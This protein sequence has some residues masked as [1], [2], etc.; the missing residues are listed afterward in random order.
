MISLVRLLSEQFVTLKPIE[1]SES[2][3]KSSY[4]S[5]YVKGSTE[6][7]KLIVPVNTEVGELEYGV[8]D[9]T[10]IELIS[11]HIAKVHRG[12]RYATD[13]VNAL[14]HSLKQK[15]IILLAAPSSKK[16]WMKLGFQPMPDAKGYF[17]KTF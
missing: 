6:F 1:P 12:K 7:F 2:D 5:P 11:I 16:F 3:F 10:T 17:T 13:A 4:H 9:D 15:T 14:G 8:V